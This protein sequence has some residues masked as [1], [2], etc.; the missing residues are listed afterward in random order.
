MENSELI[1]LILLF[2]S[3][4]GAI[5]GVAALIASAV[6]AVKRVIRWFT[7]L[8]ES[9]DMLVKHDRKQYLSILRLTVMSEHIP[10]S[11]RIAAG[12]AYAEAGG[13]GDVKRYYESRLKPYDTIE[14][15][16]NGH[17]QPYV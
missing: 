12:K 8:R 13:N 5:A 16:E 9:V 4:A 10:L 6:R 1:R 14:R 3:V 15:K 2:G 11:E 17:E 7:D